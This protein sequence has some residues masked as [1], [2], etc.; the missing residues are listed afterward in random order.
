MAAISALGVGSG[1]D[2]N[3]L[4]DQLRTSEQQKLVPISE[5]RTEEKAKISAYGRLQ[6]GLE[7]LQGAV[8]T[9]NDASTY[10]NLTANVQ[11]EGMTATVGEDASA[12]R[13]EITVNQTARAG[14]LA[15]V[16]VSDPDAA[17]VGAGGDELTLTF[18]DGSTSGPISLGE[19][20]SLED[21]RDAINA[22]E[23]A[24]VDA[25]I[26][27][28]GTSSRLVLSSQE[29]G[30]AAGI[31]SMSFANGT[32]AGDA[33]T[34]Q[35]GRDASLDINGIAIT[36]TSNTVEDAIQGVTLELEPS[37]AGETMSLV[38][39]PDT[40][41]LKESV[42]AF[43][44][45]YNE[46]K[47]TVGRMTEATGDVETAGELV[48]DR[49]VRTIQSQLSRDLTNPVSGGDLEIMSAVGI[50]LDENGR[51]ELDEGKLDEVIADNPQGL[52]DFFAGTTEE[53]GFAGR[54]AGSLDN[55]LDSEGMVQRAIDTSEGQV[56]RL[57]DRFDRTEQRIERT[58]ERY[59]S[60]FSQ[61]DGLI[62]Q[63]NSTS[64]YLSQQLAGLNMQNS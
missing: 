6:S 30:A 46:M 4:L 17:L 51:L 26:I 55:M 28:D 7:K 56:G 2:L 18:G 49:T 61:L 19:G 29:S 53:G 33:S 31:E 15:S 21:I 40:E 10:T 25:S 54:L 14:S 11:G 24:G 5:Q 12:G 8:D 48:G 64:A 43:V 52:Q 37:S 13:Y 1:L 35:A 50:S 59:R 57:E 16:G 36:S 60:Q 34:K 9:L 32:L 58:V 27:N 44:S 63:M 62:A 41:S 3:G 23:T 20:D 42:Q 38:V 47:S 45:A 22:D 39:E